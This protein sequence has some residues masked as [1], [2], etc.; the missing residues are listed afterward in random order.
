[1]CIL[2]PSGAP[3]RPTVGTGG[4]LLTQ[5]ADRH[6]SPHSAPTCLHLHPLPREAVSPGV[7]PQ[8][9]DLQ[10]H[11]SQVLD[12]W[13]RETSFRGVVLG[14]SPTQR[15]RGGAVGTRAGPSGEVEF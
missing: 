6:L 12:S 1:M 7:G 4:L 14:P 3:P 8:P 11:P 10:P 2:I 9:R 15:T 5:G 13:G